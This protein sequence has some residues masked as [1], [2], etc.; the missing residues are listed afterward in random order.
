MDEKNELQSG[1]EAGDGVK[2]EKP[3]KRKSWKKSKEFMD[4]VI[5]D[6]E[7]AKERG[8]KGGEKSG[9]VRRAKR[10]ARDSV[11]YFLGRSA[12]NKDIRDNLL[13]LGIEDEECTN[14]MA[15]QGRLFTMAMSGNLDAYLTLM[16]MGGYDPEEIRKE[17]ESIAADRRREIELDAKVAAL[18]RGDASEMAL[19]L[20][21][22]DGENDVV[23]YMPQIEAEESC[24]LKPEEKAAEDS[25]E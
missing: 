4:N 1:L 20:Q 11:Q 22:E 25:A 2:D 3:R 9:E 10:D 8:K 14:M 18:G 6:T 12:K 5:R 17:R 7:T 19:N 16:R 21:G 23:V 15:L 24:E 13:K